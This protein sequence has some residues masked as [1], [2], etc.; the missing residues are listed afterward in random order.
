MFYEAMMCF[1]SG[2]T[3]HSWLLCSDGVWDRFCTQYRWPQCLV[4]TG[5]RCTH[6]W[7]C[8]QPH[9]LSVQVRTHTMSNN[10]CD[11]LYFAY[12]LYASKFHKLGW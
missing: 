2:S 8:I 11:M 12:F 4:W 7:Q 9:A 1:D 6:R 5:V 10:A 3:Y